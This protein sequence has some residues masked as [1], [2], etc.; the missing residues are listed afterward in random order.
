MTAVA[1]GCFGQPRLVKR[2]NLDHVDQFNSLNE[3]LS[4]AVAAVHDDR[5][6]RIE[7]NQRY[8]DLA[9]ISGVNGARTV[10]D[11]KTQARS[12]TGTRVHQP[13]HA[14]RDGDRNAGGH[15]GTLTRRKLD[16]LGAV[17]VDSGV[18]VVGATGQ[19]QAGVQA[20]NRETGRHGATDYP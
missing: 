12:Q 5:G 6:D 7:I 4:D 17:Q 1:T 16:V 8:L 13:H 2:R 18:T 11:R 3:Q 20:D 10:D 9:A 14:V 15:Q 19:R